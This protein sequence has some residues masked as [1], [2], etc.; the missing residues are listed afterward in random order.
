MKLEFK[1]M[2]TNALGV[3][4]FADNTG[5]LVSKFLGAACL[6]G[7]LFFASR[8]GDRLKKWMNK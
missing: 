2:V 5:D 4:V 6:I 7:T 8:F 3:I 1:L